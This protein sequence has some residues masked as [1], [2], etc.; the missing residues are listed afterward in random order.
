MTM[1]TTYEGNVLIRVFTSQEKKRYIAMKKNIILVIPLILFILSYT[2]ESYAFRCG[3]TLV[4][5]GDSKVKVLQE[6]GKP[7][8]KEKVGTKKVR[9]YRKGDH[10][11]LERHSSQQRSFKEVTKPVEKWYYNCG[12]NDFISLLSQRCYFE[13]I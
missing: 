8:S 9:R 2:L 10:Y 12:K 3:E 6:C 11:N 13:I 7:T 5:V 4:S 1:K